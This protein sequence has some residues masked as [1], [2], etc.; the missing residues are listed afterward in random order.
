MNYPNYCKSLLTLICVLMFSLSAV[1]QDGLRQA[2][3]E[4]AKDALVS[5]NQA[6]AS[7][8]APSSYSEGAEHYKRAESIL[9]RGGNIERIRSE[10]SQAVTAWQ[11][12]VKSTE[13][14][15]ATLS[16]SIQARAD[17]ISAGAESFTP[18]LWA[19]AES[20]FQKATISLEN[21]SL[22]AAQRQNSEA[23]AQYREAE[24]AAIKSNYLNE[25]RTLLAAADK[26]KAKRYAPAT[27]A[28]AQSLYAE[29][30]RELT[31]NR[32]DTDRPR[33][34]AQDAKHEAQLAIY[35]AKNLK[36]VERDREQL[37]AYVVDWQTPVKRI[38]ATLDTPVYFDNGYEEPTAGLVEKISNLL[39]TN[40]IQSQD[41]QERKQQIRSMETQIASLEQKLGG[42]SKERLALAAELDHQ[43]RIKQK[44]ASVEKMFSRE[45]AVVLRS[46]NDV[47]LRMVGLT[48]DSGK[49]DMK[50]EWD[51][52]LDRVGK[53]VAQFDNPLLEVEGHTDAFGSDETNL[54]LSGDR[55]VAVK[56]YMQSNMNLDESEVRAIGY[57]EARP[58]ANNETAEGRAK[59]RR[60][61]I[62][63]RTTL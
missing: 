62:V 28:K 58:I 56:L 19:D 9:E 12:A 11:K 8:L 60:I 43:A 33:S 42:A 57:G 25:T 37:E 34:I 14:A 41:L 35:L 17:A 29:A 24:L 49:S 21:G 22:K 13:V 45:E 7:L 38:G 46:G 32:Y 18:E 27:F 23:E 4:E 10:L 52:L 30:E 15:N 1:A 51:E 6:R 61:D 50:P 40:R 31:E 48:F 20:Q 54:E 5:A 55:A 16:K 39:E 36:R 63:I 47:I 26:L 53:A 2:L 59:N 3:F 44:F